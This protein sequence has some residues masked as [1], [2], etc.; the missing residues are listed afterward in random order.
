LK[1]SSTGTEATSSGEINSIEKLGLIIVI[2][3]L[4][5]PF[6]CLSAFLSYSGQ[7]DLS[8]AEAP[9]SGESKSVES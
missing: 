6:V 5:T 8:A 2:S 9:P 3:G 7:F 1:F 4:L